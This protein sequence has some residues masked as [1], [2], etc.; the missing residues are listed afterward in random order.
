MRKPPAGGTSP[1]LLPTAC[2]HTLPITPQGALVTPPRWKRGAQ[3][4]RASECVTARPPALIPALTA[5]SPCWTRRRPHRSARHAVDGGSEWPD[6]DECAFAGG[7]PCTHECSGSLLRVCGRAPDRREG[8]GFQFR[9]RSPCHRGMRWG[10]RLP[11]VFLTSPTL[12]EI[13]PG[14]ENKDLARTFGSH[15][16]GHGRAVIRRRIDYPAQRPAPRWVQ[17]NDRTYAF[18]ALVPRL[19]PASN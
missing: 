1:Q 14:A 15:M 18:C 2:L 7:N 16:Y 10:S 6:V 19:E 17:K 13:L 11:I 5:R 12:A 4:I 9:P 3:R 8:R